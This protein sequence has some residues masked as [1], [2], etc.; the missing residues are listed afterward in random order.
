MRWSSIIVTRIPGNPL[1]PGRPISP[2]MPLSLDD[3]FHPEEGGKEKG[4]GPE[5]GRTK[6]EMEAE[7]K[8][9]E[10]GAGEVWVEKVRGEGEGRR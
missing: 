5:E 7:K 10:G 9:R 2:F 6:R 1:N 8:M 3:L 4:E